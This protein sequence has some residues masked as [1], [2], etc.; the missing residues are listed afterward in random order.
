MKR[1]GGRCEG[2]GS[3]E[4]LRACHVIPLSVLVGAAR[5]DVANGKLLCRKCDRRTDPAAKAQVIPN[6][7]R[8]RR[9]RE[10]HVDPSSLRLA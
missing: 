8:G 2:C 5:Y 3:T 1:A 9:P 6:H 7:P 4:D 10:R